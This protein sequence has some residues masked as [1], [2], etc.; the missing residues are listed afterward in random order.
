VEGNPSSAGESGD[1]LPAIAD[2][3]IARRDDAG[4]GEAHRSAIDLR[5]D[6]VEG[7][8]VPVASDKDGNVV[9]IKVSHA[10]PFRRAF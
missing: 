6:R 2:E 4:E 7:G 9:L 10:W 5:Q 8:A 1:R 3:M